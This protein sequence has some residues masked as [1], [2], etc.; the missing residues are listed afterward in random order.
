MKEEEQKL[1]K[2]QKENSILK[3]EVSQEDIA[4]VVSRWTNIPVSKMLQSDREKL[5]HLEDHLHERVVG[6]Q[7]AITAVA[8]AIRRSR[9]GLQDPKKPIGSFIFLG[10]TGVG[11]TELAKALADYLF[12]DENMLSVVW[13]YNRVPME[14]EPYEQKIIPSWESPIKD[15][16]TGRWISSH[17]INQDIIAWVGQGAIADRTKE[18]LGS[19]DVC[20]VA[21]RRAL[22]NGIAAVQAGK[23]PIHVF[24]DPAQNDC[25][26]I[27]VVSEV[28]PT[29]V[30]HKEFWKQRI[31]KNS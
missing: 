11:K 26:T 31:Q 24:R 18:H 27:V 1:L 25:S 3:E 2:I 21:A 23:D 22:L 12:D 15:A 7:E 13:A 17:I 28:I 5:L 30:D 10:T 6:Q 29:E 16:Q 4:K 14:R 8:D 19:T 20:I 9:A